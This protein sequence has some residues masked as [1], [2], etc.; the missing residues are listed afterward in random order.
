MLPFHIQTDKDTNQTPSKAKGR[1]ASS[2]TGLGLDGNKRLSKLHIDDK[3][4]FFAVVKVER[5]VG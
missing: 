4:V 2:P 5:R 1:G 3:N